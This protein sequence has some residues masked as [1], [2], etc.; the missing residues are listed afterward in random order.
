MG[1]PCE[2]KNS[3]SCNN[4]SFSTNHS[5]TPM[6]NS[7]RRVA[8][9]LRVCPSW[10]G[11]K[12]FA[13]LVGALI[14]SSDKYQLLY[15]VW[16]KS[17][18]CS[19]SYKP[20]NAVTHKRVDASMHDSSVWHVSTHLLLVNTSWQLVFDAS[21]TRQHTSS[22][23]HLPLIWARLRHC[24]SRVWGWYWRERIHG[25]RGNGDCS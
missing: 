7:F 9:H 25:G 10:A 8:T 20:Y 21:T 22:L 2:S 18:N 19:T 1:F 5:P 4:Y 24:H 3:K 6:A 16:N 12:P 13:L 23:T 11:Y 15:A 17:V 14:D